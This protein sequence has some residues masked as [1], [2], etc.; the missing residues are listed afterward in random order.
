MEVWLFDYVRNRRTF[1]I[2]GV[3]DVYKPRLHWR[4]TFKKVAVTFQFNL[5]RIE[6]IDL[7]VL[8]LNGCNIFQKNR[9]KIAF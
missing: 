4:K 5:Y 2:L 6:G 3:F 1:D 9:E 8:F 7:N